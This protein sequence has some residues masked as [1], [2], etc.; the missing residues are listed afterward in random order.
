MLSVVVSFRNI[1]IKKYLEFCHFFIDNGLNF[2]TEDNV[3]GYNTL[4]HAII[5][6]RLAIAINLCP[7][8]TKSFD[9]MKIGLLTN[10]LYEERHALEYLEKQDKL[11]KSELYW[12]N[13]SDTPYDSENTKIKINDA[14]KDCARALFGLSSTERAKVIFKLKLVRLNTGFQDICSY[15]ISLMKLTTPEIV[16]RCFEFLGVSFV[17]NTR[18]TIF[19]KDLEVFR[20]KNLKESIDPE[21]SSAI[22]DNSLSHLHLNDKDILIKGVSDISKSFSTL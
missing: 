7:L 14:I 5:S 16:I 22:L 15:V 9:V 3:K 21:T 2:N 4:E 10:E 18:F 6:N 12:C 8:N 1:S 13:I 17:V 19:P 20:M 11:S